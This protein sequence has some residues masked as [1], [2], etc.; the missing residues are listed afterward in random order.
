MNLILIL[1]IIGALITLYISISHLMKRDV[2]CPINRKHCNIVLNSKYSK[3]F[4]I[5]NEIIGFVYY[6]II[7]LIFLL[8]QNETTILTLKTVS[9]VVALY[10]IYLFRIQITKLKKYCSWR[11]TTAMINV[12]IFILLITSG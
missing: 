11:I 8:F 1:A 5:K 9:G 7:I 10:S 12:V 2:A 4:G 3:T 6:T